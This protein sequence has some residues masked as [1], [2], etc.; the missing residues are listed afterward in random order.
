MKPFLRIRKVTLLH[1]GNGWI[2]LSPLE[3][4]AEPKNL[5]RLKAEIKQRWPMTHLL[6]VLKETDLR[7]G[8][9]RRFQSAAS[10]ESLD[11]EVLQKRLLLGL[12]GLGTNMGLKRIAHSHPGET[13][14]TLRYVCHRYFQSDHLR[15]AI[16]DVANATFQARLPQIW[17]EATTACASDSKKGSALS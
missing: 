17:G 13:P 9:S 16:Q 6:D 11:P 2:K 5:E 1:K 10:R 7:V 15:Q 14:S 4:Q 3:A 8:F 12:Y